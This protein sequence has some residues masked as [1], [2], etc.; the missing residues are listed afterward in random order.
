MASKVYYWGKWPCCSGTYLQD[1]AD[2]HNLVYLHDD[3]GLY[4]N[5]LLPSQVQWSTKGTSVRLMLETE[6]PGTEDATAMIETSQPIEF[7]LNFRIP[8]WCSRAEISVNGEKSNAP[9]TPNQWHNL[10]RT[11]HKD[12][13]S[14]RFVMEPRAVPV[15]SQHPNR[16]VV[17]YGPLLMVQD[18]RYT[19]PIRGDQASIVPNL[20]KVSKLPELRFGTSSTSNYNPNAVLSDIN[21]ANGEGVGHFIPFWN[22]QERIPY[23]AYIDMDRKTF[24]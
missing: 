23:R 7:A 16:I 20:A 11:W 14:V 12:K 18:A 5:L 4:V 17:M 15:D 19:F 2:Y 21:L 6:Y 13:V 9:T 24:F 3:D 10:R 1:V 8:S 22:V